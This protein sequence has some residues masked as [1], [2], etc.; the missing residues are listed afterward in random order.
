MSKILIIEDDNRI[1]N[2]MTMALKSKGYSIISARNGNDGIL[3]FCT[4]NPDIILLDLGLPDM[5]G[6]DII[7]QIRNVSDIPII[8]VSAREQDNDKIAALDSGANDYVTK[9]F[10][11][12]ELLARIRVMERLI[13]R[14][15][16]YAPES[17]YK[18]DYLTVDREKHRVYVDDNE[19]HLTP[20][21][22]KLLLLLI[23]NRGKVITHSHISKEV[24]GYGETG[25]AKSIRVFM[26]SLRR[27]IEKDSSNPRFILTEIGVGYRFSDI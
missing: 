19:V 12:G 14:E 4:E 22:F 6:V 16:G 13:E 3:Y 11:M 23:A 25:D 21:E 8:I 24:W 20:I 15:I 9:P 17:V 27:K 2:F 26:A 7:K 1:T 10:S 5:D 18:S